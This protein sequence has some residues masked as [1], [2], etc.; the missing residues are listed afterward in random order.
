MSLQWHGRVWRKRAGSE[1]WS[2]GRDSLAEADV[3]MSKGQLSVLGQANRTGQISWRDNWFL[4]HSQPHGREMDNCCLLFFV[5]FVLLTAPR[6]YYHCYC[7]C[8][9]YYY[10]YYEAV[11]NAHF[12]VKATL[13]SVFFFTLSF[14]AV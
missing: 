14:S 13:N 12:N 11:L 10:Y 5:C 2:V 8:L 4:A 7:V 6:T 1:V 3:R 9:H